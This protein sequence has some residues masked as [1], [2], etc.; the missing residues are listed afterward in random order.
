M[1][2]HL[3][4]QMKQFLRRLAHSKVQFDFCDMVTIDKTLLASVKKKKNHV[5]TLTITQIVTI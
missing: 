5:D 1:I 3:S 2:M 4:F